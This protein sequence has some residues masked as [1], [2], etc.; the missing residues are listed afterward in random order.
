MILRVSR[1]MAAG[2][3]TLCAAPG[4]A[5]EVSVPETISFNRHIRPIL[6]DKCFAC[7]GPDAGSRKGDLRLDQPP[8]EG[9]TDPVLVPGNPD[10]S[11][12]VKR[13]ITTDPSNQMPPPDQE[14]Q[15]TEAQKE[16]LKAW[17]AQGGQYEPHWAYIPPVLNPAHLPEDIAQHRNPI[18]AFVMRKLKR[19]GLA[20]GPEADKITLVRR[21]HWDLLGLPPAPGVVEAYLNNP[22]PGAWETLV[23]SLLASPHYGERMAQEWLDA[24]RYADSNGYHS[25]EFRSMS[26]YRDYVINAF[27]DNMPFDR[28]TR[29]Q[30]AGDLLPEP[31]RAQKVAS[32]YNRLN[33]ITAEGGA[34][35]KEYLA[36]YAADRVRTTASVWLGATMNCAE[37][38]DHKYDP[39]ST[40]EFYQFAAFFADVEEK[41]VYG[42]GGVW[43]PFMYL[44]TPDQA[45]REEQLI[46]VIGGLRT[47][48]ATET[49]PLQQARAAWEAEL[50]AQRE[51]ALQPWTY[52]EP[53]SVKA[54]GET[55]FTV[56][57]DRR[58][59]AGGPEREQDEYTIQLPG[60]GA[61]VSRIVIEAWDDL[62][63]GNVSRG[64]GNFVMTNLAITWRAP[65]AEEAVP[66]GIARVTASHEQ[67]GQPA[68]AVLDEDKRSGWAV[69]GHIQRGDQALLLSLASP[70]Q[71]AEGGVLEIT[72]HFN[73]RFP[74]H[75]LD[76][77]RIGLSDAPASA[78]P[79]AT[80][81]A[82][83]KAVVL[84]PAELRSPGE[85]AAL[86]GHFL[87]YTP[88]LEPQRVA[89]AK[90]EAD[91]TALRGSME[92]TLVTEAR[93]EPRVMR[94]LP[95][96]NWL[97]ESGEVVA[98]GT[99]A[100]LPALGAGA[101]RATRLDLANWIVRRDNPLTARVTMNRLWKRFHGNGISKVLD[102]FGGQ[103]EWPTH[104]D[105]LDWLAVEF[106]ESGWDLKHMV[107]LMVTSDAYRRSSEAD[108][109]LRARDPYNR[110]L[111]RQSR[112][113]VEAEMV[114]D[115]ALA[116]SG[117]LVPTVGG[118]SI[119]PYQP[120]G[121]YANCNTF[122]GKIGYVLDEN[123]NQ[124][125]RGVYT[126]WKRSFLHP[127]MLAFDAP[128]REECTAER[129]ISNTP[130]QALV[131]MND[132]TFV[133]AARVFAQR[134][135]A[136]GGEE[137]DG[138]INLAF[139]RAL[140]RAPR[141][142]EVT[143]LRE[144]YHQH[145]I[146]YTND[147][148][149]ADALLST[150]FSPLPEGCDKADLAAWTSVT[151][152]ILNLH[153]TITRS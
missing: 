125:R 26:A 139:A 92:T 100:I 78:M 80:L 137:S 132:P 86:A 123:E 19:E 152:V 28:F 131:L 77:F 66:V 126:F 3:L 143:L 34:Q 24:V 88:A 10:A 98:P 134:I 104:P 72:L 129:P 106:M 89:L 18:D 27:S 115:G 5:A 47:T 35:E 142:E 67:Q 58:I 101:P 71:L 102:D 83:L 8:A 48:L 135:M 145:L 96:G 121:Y 94:V 84:R 23:D 42:S 2:A 30:I 79:W 130:L 69:D 20:P 113:R 136:E 56:M 6:S 120:E 13:I 25:D 45:A 124:Y 75:Q 147:P 151:R 55:T 110:L 57:P 36:K 44:P 140:S 31:T 65:G 14:K 1:L 144:L 32:G 114:R 91:L 60:N 118:R 119:F 111:A 117:L 87:A 133:E 51:G 146:E 153:E 68:A 4:L 128:T 54:L 150:G 12:L 107:R 90:A 63:M 33:Q 127:A 38:H 99:P 109:A 76:S 9:A 112:F 61:T 21:L 108:E 52:P 7:H 141:P 93:P 40:K 62:L 17:V 59:L 37:C 85:Q 41:G 29:E 70:Q 81:P 148:A 43:E 39:I 116:M 16:L 15:L 138:R 74:G 149:A 73:S 95:R 53:L 97:D 50:L 103:G 64:G 49:A 122:G 82:P 46:A 22:D 105:L 11:E